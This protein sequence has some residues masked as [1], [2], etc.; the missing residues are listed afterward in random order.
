MPLPRLFRRFSAVPSN[1]ASL[2]LSSL[3]TD[4]EQRI[5]A[6]L[7][8]VRPM[9]RSDGGDIEFVRADEAN[10]LVEVRL[11]GACT[12]CAA[13]I[14][15]MRFAVEARLKEAIPTIQKVVAI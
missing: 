13:S 8:R 12:H 6:V 7:E 5:L 14:F 2:D 1:K 10:G 3:P 9:L 4:Y 11:Q 15:T